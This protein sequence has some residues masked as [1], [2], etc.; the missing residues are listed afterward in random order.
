[1]TFGEELP[2]IATPADARNG[3]P[4]IRREQKKR[5]KQQRDMQEQKNNRE[6]QYCIILKTLTYEDI[7]HSIHLKAEAACR[8]DENT[9]TAASKIVIQF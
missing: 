3:T 1:M 5:K 7:T 9:H 6:K 2:A 4:Q 8:A